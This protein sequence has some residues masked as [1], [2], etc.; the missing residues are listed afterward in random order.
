[1]ELE[2]SHF[3]LVEELQAKEEDIA[4]ME[5]RRDK[6]K[7]GLETAEQIAVETQQDIE[8]KRKLLKE[9]QLNIERVRR[10]NGEQKVCIKGLIWV[11]VSPLKVIKL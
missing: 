4:S 3:Q 7:E 11:K 6:L 1:M 8:E 2:I 5:G 9:H 10:L